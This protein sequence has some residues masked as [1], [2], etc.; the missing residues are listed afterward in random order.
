[1]KKFIPTKIKDYIKNKK[2]KFI[3][4]L[5]LDNSISVSENLK[6][7]T[8][9]VIKAA[10]NDDV[11]KSFRQNEIYCWVLEHDNLK[12]GLENYKYIQK[13]SKLNKSKILAILKEH[14]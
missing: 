7:Y 10:D 4:Y 8:S 13:I 3:Y 2:K 6:E 12:R 9:F 11:F 5:K 1:M 14:A